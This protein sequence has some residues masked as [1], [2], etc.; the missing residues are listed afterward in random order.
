[1][2][3]LESVTINALDYSKRL[4]LIATGGVEGRLIIVD[5]GAKIITKE[6]KAHNAEIIDVYFYDAHY[7]I[8]T[9]AIDR[10]VHLWD[11]NKL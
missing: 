2:K 3:N 10:T 1:M 9:I 6:V 11:T 8:I 5:P 4:K 7:Q